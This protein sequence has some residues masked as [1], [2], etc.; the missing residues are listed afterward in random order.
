MHELTKLKEQFSE[1]GIL[2]C[3]NG[4]FSQSII[5]EIGNAVRKYLETEEAR[6]DAVLDVFAVYI[7]QTQN[8][9]NYLAATGFSAADQG[10]A[11]MTIARKEG[12]Y[13]L[14]SGNMI[15]KSD[16]A[17]LVERIEQINRLDKSGLKRLYREQ[18]RR[19]VSPGGKGAGVGL[20]EIARRASNKLSYVVDGIDETCDFFILSVEI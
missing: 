2:I 8:V 15:R 6:K 7:E 14:S 19:E 13:L 1:K 18:M 5:E 16:T 20:I 4:P 11:I 3:F 10:A 12:K 9:K 17:P